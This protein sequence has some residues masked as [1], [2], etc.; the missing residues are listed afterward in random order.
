MVETCPAPSIT[1][2]TAGCPAISPTSWLKYPMV[3]PRSSEICPSS[4]DSS[5]MMSRKM[6]DLPA[7]LGPT[8]PTFSP[9]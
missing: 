1:A 5:F 4:G 9:R 2:A 8:R 7:P 6:V 3:I